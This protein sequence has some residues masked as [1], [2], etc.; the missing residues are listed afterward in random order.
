MDSTSFFDEDFFTETNFSKASLLDIRDN[1]DRIFGEGEWEGLELETISLTLGI[2][3]DELMR[4]KMSFLK[5]LAF[6]PDSFFED[7]LVFLYGTEVANNN[8]A[9]FD[10]VP[11]PSTLEAIY[12]I[13]EVNKVLGENGVA[14]EDFSLGVKKTLS[15]ILIQDGF[16]HIPK[17]LTGI[18]LSWVSNFP[19][20][21]NEQDVKDRTLAIK[22]YINYMISEQK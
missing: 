4:D 10:F 19:E 14:S 5:V 11:S 15:E 12:A 7:P 3:F 2:F 6:N 9:E 22:A 8:V 20:E 1:L 13:E 17:E 21:K 18:P 16:S